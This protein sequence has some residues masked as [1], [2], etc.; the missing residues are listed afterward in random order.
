MK[1]DYIGKVFSNLTVVSEEET[2][3]TP[4]K[5]SRRFLC[6]CS[7]GSEVIKTLDHLKS[8]ATVDCGI[9]CPLK[10]KQLICGF[11]VNDAGYTTQIFK[12]RKLVDYC[13]FFLVWKNMITRCY[14]K[15][16]KNTTYSD[17]F[18]SDEWRHFSKFKAWMEKQDWEGKQ[19]DKD[20]LVPGNKAYSP[21]KCCFVD[22]RINVFIVE[23]SSKRGDSLIG[24]SFISDIGK[25]TSYCNNPFTLKMEYLGLFEDEIEAHNAWLRRK[26]EHAKLLAAEQD[27]PRVAKAL[28]E[29]YENYQH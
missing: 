6:L 22:L 25:F 7:C 18:V 2:K 24:T 23:R 27:D 14:G 21:E 5:R 16:S 26:L 10:E 12:N 28:V 15:T 4:H 17:C 11:G 1:V 9:R 20:I 29:R 3:V 19:L 13:P 8:G